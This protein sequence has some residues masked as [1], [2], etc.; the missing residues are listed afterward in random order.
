[1]LCFQCE[2][3]FDKFLAKVIQGSLLLC[4]NKGIIAEDHVDDIF[5]KP[6]LVITFQILEQHICWFSK[7]YFVLQM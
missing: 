4:F 6:L 7:Y 5:V 3:F 2:I 1:M